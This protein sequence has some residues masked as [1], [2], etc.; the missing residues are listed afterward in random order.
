MIML[1]T[2]K[3]VYVVMP[4]VLAAEGLVVLPGGYPVAAVGL[5]DRH[6]DLLH[7]IMYGMPVP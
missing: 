3:H 6:R 2:R 1:V 4:D 5:P 7:K